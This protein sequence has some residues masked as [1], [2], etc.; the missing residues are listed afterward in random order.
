MKIK[1]ALIAAIILCFGI[2][3]YTQYRA[4][5]AATP[6]YQTTKAEKGTLIVSLSASG[7]V[8]ATNSRTVTTT[9]SGIVKKVFVKEGDKVRTGTPILEIDLDLNGRQKLQAAYSSY[10]SAQNSL[11]SA[12]DK[13]YSLQSDLVSAKNVFDN[14]WS[15]QSP[16]DPTYIQKHNALLTAQAAYDNLQNT[17]KQSEVA[18]ESSRLSCQLAGAIVYAPIS[19]TVSAIS[20][21]PGMILNPTSDSSNSSNIENK[22]AIVKTNATPTVTVNLTEI[23]VP[24]AKVG[25]KVTITFDALPDKTFTGKIIAIDTAGT[26]SSNVVSYPTTIQLDSEALGVLSNMSASAN[27]IVNFKDNVLIVP[28]GAVLSQNGEST[29]RVLVNGKVENKSVE[30]GLQ[31]DTQTEIVSGINEDDEVVTAIITPS[32]TTTSTGS[33]PFGGF[34]GGRMIQLR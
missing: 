21:T 29:V 1:I 9:A 7:Q 19:G 15:M 8:A 28:N 11:K 33:S 20:L 30:I 6:Q 17:L 4:K 22:I 3:A 13:F 12:Q 18:L 25:N 24:K 26:V 2:F 31:S 34:G 32:K 14:Q 16:D 23:D 5:K 27:I 10:L